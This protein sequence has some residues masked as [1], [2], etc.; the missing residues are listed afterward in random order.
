MDQMVAC[1]DR[2]DPERHRHDAPAQTQAGDGPHA[3]DTAQA[4]AAGD[5]A[6]TSGRPAFPPPSPEPTQC[7]PCDIR[8]DFNA[9]ARLRLPPGDFRARLLD[10]ETGNILFQADRGGV[11]IASAK[12]YFVPFLIEVRDG[13]GGLLFRHRYDA[14]DREVLI[15]LPVG[16]IGDS[17]GWLP[18]A[19]RFQ[20][21][22]GCRLTI[23]LAERLIPLVR[24]AYPAISFVTHEQVEPQRYYATYNIGLFFDDVA[25]V[26]QPT[27][28]RLVGLHRTAGYILGVD[29]SEQAPR[30]SLPDEARPIPEP[31]VC[32]AVQ[33]SS[34]A[35]KWNN[36]FGWHE[37]VRTLLAQGYRVVCID[38]ERSH[39]QGLAWTHIPHGAEDQT[40]D[41]PLV[42]RAR[43]LR[44]AAAFVG[45]SSGLAWLGWAAGCPVVMISGFT[46]PTNEFATPGRVINWHACNSCWNDPRHRFEH[47]DFLWCPR[48]KDTPRAFECTRLITAEQVKA[49]LR[50]VGLPSPALPPT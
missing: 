35:K 7:G 27:D 31:Y 42:E 20:Q 37:V 11:T 25:C 21:R 2:A 47:K 32:I 34:Q 44:H 5:V 22:H 28:F 46:H 50:A 6:A 4:S 13:S 36:P 49:A 15:T 19:V 45:G 17:I 10:A 9:G 30:L 18:Y 33:A 29:P 43:W 41:R 14:G 26:W 12:R 16:T 23:A 24:D 38:R 1:L 8:Y 39:G 48:H 40:G 3:S